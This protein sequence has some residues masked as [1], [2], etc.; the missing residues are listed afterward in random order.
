MVEKVGREVT[1]GP[2]GTDGVVLT[3]MRTKTVSI[4]SEPIDVTSDDDDG[5]RK[6]LEAPG[7]RSV[8]ISAEGVSKDPAVIAA[9]INGGLLGG[10]DLTFP[11][12]GVLSGTWRLNSGENVAAYN[13]AVT[14]STSFQSSGEITWTPV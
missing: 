13:D 7:M 9:L 3:G 10:Y 6:L 4:N 12:W 2:S 5:W 8:D 14:F 1:F 11:G